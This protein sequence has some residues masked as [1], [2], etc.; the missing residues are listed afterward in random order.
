M[1]LRHFTTIRGQILALVTGSSV[2]TFL[3]F[4]GLL[5]LPG[6]PPSPPWPWQTTYRVTSLVQMLRATPPEERE[7]LQGA[8][9]A[10]GL[11]MTLL[12]S[13]APCPDSNLNSRDLQKAL[14]D[15]LGPE[16]PV[17]AHACNPDADQANIQILVPLGEQTLEVRTMRIEREP[18]RFSFPFFGALLFLCVGVAALSAWAALRVVRPLRRLS[19]QAE[20]F[21]RDIVVAPIVEEGPL[22]IRRAAHAFNLM[23]QRITASI[24]GRTRMLAAVSHDLRT[25]LTRMRLQLETDRKEISRDKLIR[26]ISLLQTMVSSALAYLSSSSHA[27]KKE[28]LDLGALL[29]TL[30]DDYEDA[31]ANIAYDGPL[32][33][34]FLCRPD[35][36][37]R[38]MCNL[39]DN[40][41]GFA[42]QVMVSA[43]AVDGVITVEVADNG[44]GIDPA[45]LK[46]V[47]EPFFRLDPSRGD[48]PG[49]VGLGLS[50][51]NDIV[52]AHNGTLSLS[53][54]TPHGLLARIVFS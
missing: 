33:L 10:L 4:L 36:I 41:L 6:G 51:V 2:V 32:Q 13:I 28:R 9:Q 40:A 45:R 22:E 5:F 30:C 48:R 25:P 26:D 29:S 16:Q 27:E 8:A 44:P 54:R 34:T 42:T 11:K 19:D 31:G 20:A 47:I 18:P 49:S 39:I 15:E 38:V 21:G 1:I 17:S 46:D 53:N 50:I 3:I 37:Q 7:H 12:P 23:Q 35:A 52:Q 43:T 24:E 14:R